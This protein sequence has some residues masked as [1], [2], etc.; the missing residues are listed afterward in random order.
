MLYENELQHSEFQW[1]L[2]LPFYLTVNLVRFINRL[3][4]GFPYDCHKKY[5]FIY[6]NLSAFEMDKAYVRS[7]VETDILYKIEVNSSFKWLN[8]I[9]STLSFSDCNLFSITYD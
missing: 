8:C 4:L 5:R 9:L 1:L 6:L 7:K 2:H 3:Y